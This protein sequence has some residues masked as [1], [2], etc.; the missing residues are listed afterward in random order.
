MHLLTNLW[1]MMMKLTNACN[2][3]HPVQKVVPDGNWRLILKHSME[4]ADHNVF[5]IADVK[6][7]TRKK[8]LGVPPW[9]S[10]LMT[11]KLMR[12]LN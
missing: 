4:K 11:K 10:P 12:H 6:A 5:F 7:R 3:K 1:T 2:V 8:M 9:S